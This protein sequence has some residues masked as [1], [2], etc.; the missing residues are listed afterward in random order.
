MFSGAA[1]GH[2]HAG[3][4]GPWVMAALRDGDV[5]PPEGAPPPEEVQAGCLTSST[6][7][8]C[9]AAS[10]THRTDTSPHHRPHVHSASL[11][12][13]AEKPTLLLLHC[14]LLNFFLVFIDS[15]GD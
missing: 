5:T 3:Q 6:L 2:L 10:W 7:H 4:G 15:V 1:G 12:S 13:I 11:S 8:A 14:P 9:P